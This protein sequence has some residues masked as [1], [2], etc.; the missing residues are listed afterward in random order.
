MKTIYFALIIF[1]VSTVSAQTESSVTLSGILNFD[2]SPELVKQNPAN[3]L[4]TQINGTKKSPLLAGVLS[5]IVPGAGEIYNEN[6]LKSAIFIAVEAAAITVGIIYDNKGDDQTAFFENYAEQNWSSAQY[7]QWT[8]D[9]LGS[10]NGSLDAN[11]FN[12]FK[13][14]QRTTVNWNELNRLESSI[15]AWYSHKLAPFGDQQYYEMIG[16]YPQFNPGW[17]DFDINSGYQYGDPLTKNFLYYSSLRGDAN[18][19]YA[20]AKTAVNIIVINHLLSAVDAAWSASR[21]N[22]RI[23]MNVSMKSRRIG[24]VKEYFPELNLKYKF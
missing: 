10:L 16:K 3:K 9:N 22:K 11:D 17:N 8:L 1:A 4:P 6:Y 2:N 13:D 24:Y 15:G 23:D 19:F 12:V 20:I 18:D 7:A 5:F 21:Y 14:E